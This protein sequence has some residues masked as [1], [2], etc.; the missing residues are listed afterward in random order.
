M[1]Y[2]PSEGAGEMRGLVGAAAIVGFLMVAALGWSTLA[3]W[4][5]SIAPAP[6]G[7]QFFD[8][9]ARDEVLH[10]TYYVVASAARKSLEFGLFHVL[11]ALLCAAQANALRGALTAGWTFL[12]GAALAAG[13]QL[14]GALTCCVVAQPL[15]E[16]YLDYSAPSQKLATLQNA[17][18]LAGFLIALA[19]W[20]ML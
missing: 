3:V 6:A 13:V 15:P 19:G 12:T 20:P 11:A 14:V 9:L 4:P 17:V 5:G 1:C 16:T 10:A 18:M 7:S 8:R 2:V